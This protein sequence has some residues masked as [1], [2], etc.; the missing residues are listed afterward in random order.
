M[1]DSGKLTANGKGVHH[2][3]EAEE[4]RMP[5]EKS[6][7]RFSARTVISSIRMRIMRFF[8]FEVED[9]AFQISWIFCARFRRSCSSFGEGSQAFW[10]L[11][12]AKSY[13]AF[14]SSE[15]FMMARIFS[16][17]AWSRALAGTEEQ[18]ALLSSPSGQCIRIKDVCRLS[19][20]N[21]RSYGGRISQIRTPVRRAAPLRAG[22]HRSEFVWSELRRFWFSSNSAQEI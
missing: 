18:V 10:E 13:F 3:V 12:T 20:C 7:H 5:I 19:P 15:G 14:S 6:G 2:E 22:P 8:S 21:G 4:S 17:T 1:P 11:Y 9:G 16:D